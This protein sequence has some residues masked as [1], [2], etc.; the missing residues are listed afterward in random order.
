VRELVFELTA[1]RGFAIGGSNRI[2]ERTIRI[3][4]L[5]EDIQRDPLWQR[6]AEPLK[7]E[8]AR[9]AG[10][11]HRQEHRLVLPGSRYEN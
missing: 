9:F 8:L 6:Q 2:A 4:E 1:S 5:V 10:R 7:H 3:L 11:A